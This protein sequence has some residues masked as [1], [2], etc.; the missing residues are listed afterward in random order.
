LILPA[1]LNSNDTGDLLARKDELVEAIAVLARNLNLPIG[2]SFDMMQ[3]ARTAGIRSVE[4]LE[5]LVE[6]EAIKYTLCAR[7]LREEHGE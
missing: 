1:P 6:L 2:Y 7:R 3:D 5:I 4:L